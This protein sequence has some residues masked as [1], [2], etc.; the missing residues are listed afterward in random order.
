MSDG[1]ERAQYIEP[2]APRGGIDEKSVTTPEK[3]EERLQHEMRRID[4]VN[5][6]ST[7]LFI[8]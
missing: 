7:V 6:F 8:L 3:P 4:K 2:L 1:I 5:V